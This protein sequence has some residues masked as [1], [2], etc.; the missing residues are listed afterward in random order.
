MRTY[1]AGIVTAYGAAKV[2]GYTGTYEEFCAALGALANVL[3]ELE[4]FDVDITTLPAGEE[5]TASY[6]DCVLSL[7]IPKGDKGDTGATGNGIVSIEKTGTSGLVDTY[8]IL[9]TDGTSTTFTVTNGEKGDKG[10]TGATGATGNGIAGITLTST[11]GAVKTYTILYTDGTS[12]TF[13][14]TDGEITKAILANNLAPEYDP[15]STYEIGDYRSHD[16]QI[17]R[18]I[19]PITTAEAWTASHWIAVALGAD[20]SNLKS[21]LDDL[22]VRVDTIEELDGVH[23]YGVS[24]LLNAS[25]TLTRLYDAVGL[26]AAVGTD[27]EGAVN[28]FDD[29]TPFNRRKC[30][31]TWNLINGT[32]VFE[33]N[34]YLGDDDYAE[35]GSMGDYV[36]VECPRAFYKLDGATLEISAHQYPGYRPF[37][38]FCRNHNPE[39]TM[40]YCYLPAYALAINEDGHAVCLPGYDNQQGDY[41]SLYDKARTYKNGAL[42]NYA[43]L[44]PAAVN[45]YEWALFTVEFATLNCQS[46]MQGCAGLR[47]NADDRVVFVDSTHVLFQNYY[48]SRVDGEFISIIPTNVDINNSNYLATHKIISIIRSDASGNPST[49][50]TYQYAEV[51][52]LGKE[53]TTYD[54]TGETQYRVAA[55]PYRTGECNSVLT[56]SGSP[57]SNRDSYHPMRYRYRENVYSN[58]YKTA[59]D[60]FA[61]RVGTDADDYYLEWYYIADPTQITTPKNYSVSDLTDELF[62]KLGIETDHEYYVSGYVK[63]K[64]YDAEFPDIWIPYETT[65]ASTATYFCDFAY[66]VDSYVLRAVR[67]GGSWYAGAADGFSDVNAIHAPSYANASFGGDLCIAQWG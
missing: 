38:I 66:L 42:G 24:G 8:T 12:T 5:A 3:E 61:L 52:D 29:R 9:Y 22:T 31:G 10:D 48:A 56:P 25:P 37:D 49:T 36:A 54:Y 50:G 26:T 39:D 21:D 53:Y 4:N 32:P 46:I 67:F 1:S 14:V 33:V 47:H 60:L 30:V 7:G 19:V 13:D 34:A 57:V 51:E 55:R 45:F 16:G 43:M 40:P 28:D 17:Y 35:D 59:A 63:S 58:Q 20:V 18:C 2:G 11:S 64:L 65:G 27:T 15:A 62:T 6:A 41:K 44:Q 23:R